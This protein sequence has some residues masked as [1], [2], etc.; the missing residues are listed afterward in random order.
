MLNLMDENK[1]STNI[2]E[3]SINP[4]LVKINEL[5]DKSTEAYQKEDKRAAIE[6]YNN[7][8]KL[9]EENKLQDTKTINRFYSI[10]T[11]LDE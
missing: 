7:A 2:P 4:V 6:Y 9:F 1:I 3:I 10:S 11:S 5:L 8:K